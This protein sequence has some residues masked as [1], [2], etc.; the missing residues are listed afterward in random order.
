[1]DVSKKISDDIKLSKEYD[2]KKNSPLKPEE[3]S[4]GSQKKLWWRCTNNHPSHQRRVRDK[5]KTNVSCPECRSLKFCFPSIFERVCRVKN[6][7]LDIDRISKSSSKLIWWMCKFGHS[8]KDTPGHQI[9]GRGCSKCN[10]GFSRAQVRF[11]CELSYIFKDISLSNKFK[12]IDEI[13]KTF[14][15]N[16]KSN[17]FRNNEVDIY[18]KSLWL[19]I[20]YDGF[21]YHKNKLQKDIIKNNQLTKA[22][23]KIF[24]I[25]E[26][27][28]QKIEPSDLIIDPHNILKKDIDR[29]LIQISKYVILNKYIENK[30]HNYL[31]FN[32]FKCEKK[33]LN[34]INNI[35]IKP[36]KRNI[37]D[38][39]PDLVKEWD[40]NKNQ[41]LIPTNFTK[42][43]NVEVWWTCKNGHSFKKKI[44]AR[45]RG[46]K[47]VKCAKCT[48][49]IISEENNFYATMPEL[50]LFI[51][52]KKNKNFN[53]RNFFANSKK[54][55]WWKCANNHSRRYSIESRAVYFRREKKFGCKEC[56]N[57]KLN[58][59]K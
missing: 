25:R 29:L 32:N 37:Q 49:Q 55:I 2:Y 33:Y 19:G 12:D 4:L 47:I 52:Y 44:S 45:T 57:K 7:G 59:V 42:G 36:G 38:Q 43:S 26:K 28:L 24:R 56:Q 46:G 1:M 3:V 14:K 16:F 27:P 23:I 51:D 48:N 20:E 53:P 31:T 17:H 34:I 58:I 13:K 35:K 6:I 9:Q 50:C 5:F 21:Y 15:Q 30:I 41:P 18:I 10:V 54:I 40:Y 22:G 11:Y 8:Y 39:F